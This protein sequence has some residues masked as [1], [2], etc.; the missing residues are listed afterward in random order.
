[1]TIQ[2]ELEFIETCNKTD[3][4]QHA[5][6]VNVLRTMTEPNYLLIKDKIL[7]LLSK[8]NLTIDDILPDA[9]VI[10]SQIYSR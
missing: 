9:R 8:H 1:M 7:S 10:T 3:F 6:K 5:K 4:I 2:E